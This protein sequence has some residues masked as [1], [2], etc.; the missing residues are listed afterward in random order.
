MVAIALLRLGGWVDVFR[1]DSLGMAPT[2]CVG[3]YFLVEGLSFFWR[4]ARRGEVIVFDASTVPA[5][6]TNGT[7]YWVQRVVALP[8][9]RCQIKEGSVWINGVV[10]PELSGHRYGMIG[11]DLSGSGLDLANEVTV[12]PHQYVVLGDNTHNSLDSRYW[13][14]LPQKSIKLAYVSHCWRSADRSTRRPH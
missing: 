7:C 1:I 10:A 6:G 8:G 13:G 2:V 3:D 14:F 4:D 11:P 12:P 9:D 5:L